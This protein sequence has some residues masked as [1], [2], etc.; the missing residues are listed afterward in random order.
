L[1][2]TFFSELDVSEFFKMNLSDTH[3]RHTRASHANISKARRSSVFQLG[4]WARIQS[5][6]ASLPR[7]TGR[8]GVDCPIIETLNTQRQTWKL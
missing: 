3:L 1:G 4:Y 8:S 2:T 7:M 5:A 6:G